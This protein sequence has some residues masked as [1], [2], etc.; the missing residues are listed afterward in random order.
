M[1]PIVR[2]VRSMITF[3]VGVFTVVGIGLIWAGLSCKGLELGN[4]PCFC[5]KNKGF[6]VPLCRLAGI[7]TCLWECMPFCSDYISI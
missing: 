3:A 4:G 6:G 1:S 7:D 2:C 5:C